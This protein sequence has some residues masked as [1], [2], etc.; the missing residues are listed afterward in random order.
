MTEI[1][2]TFSAMQAM[3]CVIDS[4]SQGTHYKLLVFPAYRR[5]SNLSMRFSSL[6][7]YIVF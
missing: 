3:V 4:G 5:I 2:K 6:F 7:S 1:A